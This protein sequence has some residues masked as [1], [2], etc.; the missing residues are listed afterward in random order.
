MTT[1][2]PERPSLSSAVEQLL[3]RWGGLVRSA[4]RRYGFDGADLEEIE[5]DIRIRLWRVLERQGENPRGV[6]ASYVQDAA[7]SAAI[8]LLRRRRRERTHVTLDRV[9]DL[10][11]AARGAM[12]LDG[13]VE[14]LDLALARLAPDR[15]IA[16]RLHLEGESREAIARITGWSEARTR[17]LLYR[18]LDDLRT[19]RGG[20]GAT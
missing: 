16:V 3:V 2:P 15:R 11:D 8:D 9:P 13:L 7:R 12:D 14:R 20:E 18:G 19:T 10:P 5:Q 1:N 17:N 6:G 4:A